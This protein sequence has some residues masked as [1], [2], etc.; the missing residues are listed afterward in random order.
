VKFKKSHPNKGRWTDWS[1]RRE[2]AKRREELLVEQAQ[3]DPEVAAALEADRKTTRRL[4]IAITCL[5]VGAV[6]LGAG[7][8]ILGGWSGVSE[9]IASMRA[10]I[11]GA[12]N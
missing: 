1:M 8:F 4:S 12:G 11:Q 2:S 7:Y 6:T 5:L 3:H 9:A 10:Q